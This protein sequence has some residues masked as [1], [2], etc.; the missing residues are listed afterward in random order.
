VK[1]GGA[2][3]LERGRPRPQRK[4]SGAWKLVVVKNNLLIFRV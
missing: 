3:S 2:L 4:R 1:R